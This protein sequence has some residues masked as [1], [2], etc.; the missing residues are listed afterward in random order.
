MIKENNLYSPNTI[1]RIKK[2]YGFNL[3]KGL[4]QNFLIDKN[5]VDEIIYGSKI[6]N[7]TLVIE[8]G[9]G[10]GVLTKEAAEIANKVVAI[11]LDRKLIP[12]LKDNL[13]DYNNIEIINSDVL[14]TD[15]SKIIAEEKAKNDKIKNVRVIGNLPYYITTPIVMKLLEDRI[16]VDSITVM[17]Q[18]EVAERMS[19]KPG[20]K[21]CGAITYAVNYYSEA[22]KI[23]DVSKNVFYPAPKVD[24]TVIRMDIKGADRIKLEDER[25]FFNCIKA[26]FGQRRKTLL[27]SLSNLENFS[28]E[29]IKNALNKLKIDE[30]RRAETLSVEEFASVSE[31]LSKKGF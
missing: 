19:A 17:M 21:K 1:N 8:I 10:I 25:L 6:D 9:P 30:K 15:I 11:E 20:T 31:C 12:I 7:E 22:I 27:N 14:K 4:G 3:S 23:C 5:I 2:A 26:G 18:K 13:I 29:D 28:K 16:E 24:S